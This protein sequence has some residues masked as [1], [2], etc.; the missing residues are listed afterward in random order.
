MLEWL[1]VC[2]HIVR[3]DSRALSAFLNAS[4]YIDFICSMVGNLPRPKVDALC[5][6]GQPEIGTVAGCA[7]LRASMV[8]VR[9]ILSIWQHEWDL[10]DETS[11]LKSFPFL[12]N[13]FLTTGDTLVA[14]AWRWRLQCARAEVSS[15]AALIHSPCELGGC[16][17]HAAQ[18]QPLN[19]GLNYKP[20]W[21]IRNFPNKLRWSLVNFMAH[22]GWLSINWCC[23]FLCQHLF[24]TA[25]EMFRLH[26]M[27]RYSTSTERLEASAIECN[28]GFGAWSV[29]RE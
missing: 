17:V 16:L 15:C 19:P 9:A 8:S 21:G 5:W 20:F 29:P 14:I 2:V 7:I 22:L 10:Q 27:Y 24:H 6:P 4:I 1:C 23:R 13:T 18:H 26:G 12:Q 25:P 3:P 11:V 28:W